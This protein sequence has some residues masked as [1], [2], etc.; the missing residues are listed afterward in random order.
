M[1]VFHEQYEHDDQLVFFRC[2]ECGYI[3][4]SLGLLHSHIESHWS[5]L[6][7][8]KFHTIGWLRSDASDKWMEYTEIR[9]VDSAS[10]VPLDEVSER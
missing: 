10:E 1:S 9:R 8:L 7:S 5:L 3:S 6:G 2:T 4:M